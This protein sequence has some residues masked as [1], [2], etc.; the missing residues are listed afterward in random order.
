MSIRSRLTKHQRLC[1]L[2]RT[3][4]NLLFPER[5]FVCG[6]LIDDA[7]A[8]CSSC[9]SRLSFDGTPCCS[10]CGHPFEHAVPEG[11]LCGAC[12]RRPP[13]YDIAR[14]AVLYDDTSRELVLAFKHADRTRFADAFGLWML[15]AGARILDRADLIVP[16]PL[17]QRRLLRRRCNQSLLL[18]RALT[19]YSG[20]PTVPDLLQRSRNTPCKV[21]CRAR[22]DDGTFERLSRCGAATMNG[23]AAR[24]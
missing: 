7:G 6:E 5:C 24:R 8:I 19:G 23:S 11:A 21:V 13:P 14:A 3:T 15:R 9:W 12:V 20:V 18:A 2:G 17:H 16:V 10:C 1:A 22:R 4:L